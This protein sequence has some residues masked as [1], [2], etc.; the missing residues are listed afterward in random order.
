M[1]VCSTRHAEVDYQ[2]TSV[3]QCPHANGGWLVIEQ[4]SD[5]LHNDRRWAAGVKPSLVLLG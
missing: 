3:Q 5:K 4:W 2:G 1:V